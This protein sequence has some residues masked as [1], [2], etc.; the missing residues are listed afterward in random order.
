MT[1]E[2]ARGNSKIE[3]FTAV[4]ETSGTTLLSAGKRSRVRSPASGAL[5]LERRPPSMG[6]SFAIESEADLSTAAYDDLFCFIDA[7]EKMIPRST[8]AEREAESN[9]NSLEN[10]HQPHPL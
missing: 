9:L 7:S 6:N 10:L 4:L 8:E 3:Q 1:N 5:N 2:S